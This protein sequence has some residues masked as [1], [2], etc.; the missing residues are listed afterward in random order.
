MRLIEHYICEASSAFGLPLGV[1]NPMDV[2]DKELLWDVGITI[3][4]GLSHMFGNMYLDPLD[5][6]AKGHSGLKNIFD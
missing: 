2:P 6:M 3:G 5:Q 1:K 4:G